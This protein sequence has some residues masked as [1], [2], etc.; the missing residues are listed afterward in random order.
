MS[1]LRSLTGPR[2]TAADE[3]E[4][5]C[6][7]K[8]LDAD[9]WPDDLIAGR[10]FYDAWGTPVAPDIAVT[11]RE[12]GGVPTFI[13]TPPDA[14][15]DR[16]GIWLHGG[17][18]VFGSQR[19]HGAMVAEGA[20]AAGFR[21]LHPQYRRAP[22]H[23]FPA[24]LEDAVAVYAAV[25]G[26]GRSPDQV[27]MI[28]DSAGGGL[29]VAT[30]L[31]ARDRGLPMPR[32]VA[33]ISPWTDLAC[34]GET[35]RTLAADDPLVS[36]SVTLRVRD[37]YL[38]GGAPRMPYAS[39]LYGDVRGFPEALIQVG[40]RELLRSDAER[41]AAK[42]SAAG[43]PVTLEVWPGMVHVW[44]LHHTRLSKGRAG[45]ARLGSFLR[46]CWPAAV[47]EGDRWTATTR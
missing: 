22:E 21:F 5:A 16:T 7:L 31:A 23:K 11:E 20:R 47:E 41:L 10:S 2:M 3:P 45:L 27:A 39:P 44:H 14:D 40:E 32:A 9:E 42:L 19:S 37:A 43:S 26:E 36:P 8:A 1:S 25:L 17:G 35:F 18:Y 29:V 15:P 13:H 28:G 4:L 46:S 24:A 6:L 30:L 34:T 33:C 12:V 38:A